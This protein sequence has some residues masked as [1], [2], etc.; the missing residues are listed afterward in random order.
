MSAINF[1][2]RTPES[3][4]SVAFKQPVITIGRGDDPDL[5]IQ[6]ADTMV[7]RQ[8]GRIWLTADGFWYEDT[9]STSGSKKN[10]SLIMGPVRVFTGDIISVGESTLTIAQA[11]I[12][13][14]ELDLNELFVVQ[15]H[16]RLHLHED[17]ISP[18]KP[19]AKVKI[20]A[21]RAWA[22][23]NPEVTSEFSS[24]F[25]GNLVNIFEYEDQLSS[26]L[27]LAI[28]EIV[29]LFN[30]VERGAILMLDTAGSELNVA[31]HYPLFE[32]AISTSLVRKTLEEKKAFI[33][34]ADQSSFSS[35]SIKKLSIK[36]GLYSPLAFGP[37]QLGVICADT[38]SSTVDIARDDLELFM[39]VTQVLSA[40]IYARQL[41]RA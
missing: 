40:L 14:D 24:N 27:G 29:R 20:I 9:N 25:F 16:D 22:K 39:N 38:T 10:G 12:S 23:T 3:E 7:S 2:I 33:W 37:N 5:D 13:D 21:Q 28:E 19:S 1:R 32:P 30:P 18:R 8:H 17:S 26:C 15:V 31:A 41:E 4:W 35:S 36:M 11:D 6:I 34:K